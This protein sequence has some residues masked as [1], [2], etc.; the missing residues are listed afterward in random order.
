MITLLFG[1]VF[2][3]SHDYYSKYI[4]AVI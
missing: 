1:S 3:C 2:L 4:P